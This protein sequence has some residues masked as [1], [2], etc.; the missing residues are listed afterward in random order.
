[1]A[2][3]RSFG[4]FYL[5][6]YSERS[7]FGLGQ[8]KQRLGVESLALE[9]RKRHGRAGRG[10]EVARYK[11]RPDN[12]NPSGRDFPSRRCLAGFEYDDE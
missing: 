5:H 6:F 12:K 9:I 7:L 1:M 11:V 2:E 10:R 4:V 8:G 3:Y